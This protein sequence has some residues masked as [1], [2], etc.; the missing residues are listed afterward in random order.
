MFTGIVEEVGSIIEN[1]SD[2]NN[3]RI[4]C[5]FDIEKIDI[6][7]SICCD[8]ICLTVSKKGKTPDSLTWFELLVNKLISRGL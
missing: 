3:F 5:S 7:A 2:S 4:S 1:I 8:G 6:G